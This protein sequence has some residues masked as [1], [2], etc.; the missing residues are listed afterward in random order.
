MIARARRAPGTALIV[1]A[2]LALTIGGCGGSAVKP[3]TYVKSVCVALGNWRNTIQSA[4]VALQSSGAS[5]ASRPV[6]KLD[7]L[8]F[9][10]SLVIATRRATTALH[11]AGAPSVKGGQQIAQRLTR[12]FDRASRGLAGATV[13]AKAIRTDTA[14]T[15]QLGASAVN[16]Q[17]RSALGQI[18]GVSPGLSQELRSAATKEP[19][20][21]ALASNG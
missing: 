4:G 1:S 9:I 5:N 18:A 20:C 2:A 12:A 3:S 7:Y 15:F 16:A 17:I 10:N 8:R 14:T 11:A 21:Q 13:Q 19:A 6:A